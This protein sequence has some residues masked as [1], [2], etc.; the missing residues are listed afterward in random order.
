MKD[1]DFFMIPDASGL[2]KMAIFSVLSTGMISGFLKLLWFRTEG[3]ST[4]PDYNMASGAA[5]FGGGNRRSSSA[6]A[7]ERGEILFD[8]RYAC[9][10]GKRTIT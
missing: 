2:R 6:R 1:E 4:V 8:A 10:L 3:M 5:L 9:C 7:F